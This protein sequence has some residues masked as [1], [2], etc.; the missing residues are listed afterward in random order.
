MGIFDPEDFR[1]RPYV[2]GLNQMGH[3]V[4]GAALIGWSNYCI[5]DNLWICLA[6]AYTLFGGWEIHQRLFKGATRA[7]FIADLLYWSSGALV[8]AALIA[9]EKII[10]S[11]VMFPTIPLCAWVIEYTRLRDK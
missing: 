6:I 9:Y 1:G 8:W 4:F 10:G 11:G 2:G 3:H 7:D 5:T